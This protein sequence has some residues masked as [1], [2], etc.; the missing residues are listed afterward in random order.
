MKQTHMLFITGLFCSCVL[1]SA[2]QFSIEWY[3][4]D[5]GGGSSQ[6]TSFALAGTSGQ[7]DATYYSSSSGTFS[8]TGGFWSIV[9]VQTP[10]TPTLRIQL[11][12]T[13]TVVVSW[14]SSSAGYNLQQNSSLL[15]PNWLAP[16]EVVHNDGTTMSIV[17][18]PPSGT[19]YYRLRKP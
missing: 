2:Q 19:R 3:T 12:G 13:N 6:S 7:P 4:F 15:N 18:N 17:V 14:P 8:V 10:G 16:A 9:A 5:G 11:T 1:S